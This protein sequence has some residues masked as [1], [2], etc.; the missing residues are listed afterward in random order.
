MREFD[1]LNAKLDKILDKLGVAVPPPVDGKPQPAP[2]P[3]PEAPPAPPS[4]GDILN[5]PMPQPL[6][7]GQGT[8]LG[9]DG[10]R[11]TIVN[12]TPSPFVFSFVVPPGY[13]S[14]FSIDLLPHPSEAAGSDAFLYVRVTGPDGVLLNATDTVRNW[15]GSFSGMDRRRQQGMKPGNYTVSLAT[16][17]PCLTIIAVAEN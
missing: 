9:R 12:L 5:Q 17:K 7:L 16:N 8:G 2:A 10:F 1:I 11:Q 14:V 6:L 13:A 3:A 15:K 4:F